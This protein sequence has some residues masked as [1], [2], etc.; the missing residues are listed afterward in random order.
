MVLNK[1]NSAQAVASKAELRA[2][3]RAHDLDLDALAAAVRA[4]P[5]VVKRPRRFPR[6]IGFAWRFCMGAQGT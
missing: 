3:F 1:Y 2:F 5:G 4:R 6:Q